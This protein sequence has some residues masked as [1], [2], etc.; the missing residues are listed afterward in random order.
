VSNS[1][2]LV[3]NVVLSYKSEFFLDGDL[4]PNLVQGAYTKVDAR[5]GVASL[6]NTWELSLYGRNLTDEKTHTFGVDSPL[7]AGIFAA[8]IE[9]PRT[10]GIQLRYNF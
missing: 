3:G 6:S 5:I 9:E 7:S 4:D 10:Y 1:L 2:R 8:W